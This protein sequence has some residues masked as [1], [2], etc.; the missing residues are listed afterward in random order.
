MPHRVRRVKERPVIAPAARARRVERGRE[1]GP[2]PRARTAGLRGAHDDA[3]AE[4]HAPDA[5]LLEPGVAPVAFDGGEGMPC[6]EARDARAEERAD[7]RPLRRYDAPGNWQG[8]PGVQPPERTPRAG[9]QREL[10]GSDASAR[11]QN[12]RELAHD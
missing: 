12:T 7:A 9:G 5:H 2:R 6:I 11:L 1:R 8:E 10:Q 3:A 4:A